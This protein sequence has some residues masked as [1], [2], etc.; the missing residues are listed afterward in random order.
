[1]AWLSGPYSRLAIARR[2]RGG[3][4]SELMLIMAVDGG[5]TGYADAT[6]PVAAGRDRPAPCPLLPKPRRRTLLLHANSPGPG[7]V[8]TRTENDP[9]DLRDPRPGEGLAAGE[10]GR[11]SL[12]H[13]SSPWGAL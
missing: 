10:P 9:E 12:R 5:R 11:A 2:S 8:A 4:H 13:A 3:L 7:V 6:E 1:M